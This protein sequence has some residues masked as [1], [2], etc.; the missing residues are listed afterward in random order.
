MR[1]RHIT[2][3]LS[4]MRAHRGTEGSKPFPSRGESRANSR[5]G[6][7][8]NR[9]RAVSAVSPRRLRQSSR[10]RLIGTA[11]AERT[12]SGVRRFHRGSG[13]A[14]HASGVGS[15]LLTTREADSAR[16]VHP[17]CPSMSQRNVDVNS[18]QRNPEMMC[19]ANNSI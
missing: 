13:G 7:G 8:A 6:S 19:S 17:K 18:A 16:E 4:A 3:T 11:R 9:I 10:P 14:D 2:T 15:F 1:R 12:W 5:G